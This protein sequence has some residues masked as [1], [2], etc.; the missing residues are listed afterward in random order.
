MRGVAGWLG[1]ERRMGA[2]GHVMCGCG[3]VWI[4]LLWT[5][6][7][8]CL[9]QDGSTPL[10]A[11]VAGSHDTIVKGLLEKHADVNAM[12]K[13]CVCLW[14]AAWGSCGV[15]AGTGLRVS[16]FGVELCSYAK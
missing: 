11:A 4:G 14:D 13:V 6:M 8:V 7:A 5:V 2:C 15:W 12:S 9:G 16:L 3:G 1:V 10:L